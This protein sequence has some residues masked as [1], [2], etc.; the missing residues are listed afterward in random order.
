MSEPLVP[1]GSFADPIIGGQSV[2]VRDAIRSRNYVAGV[3]GWSINKDGTAELNGVV[4]RGSGI[5][6]TPGGERVEITNT[7]H[8]YIY[9]SANVLI[10]ALDSAGLLITDP[11][12]SSYAQTTLAAG[13]TVQALQPPAVVGHTYGPAL[14][15]GDSDVSGDAWAKVESPS[16]DGGDTGSILVYGENA[17]IGGPTEIRLNGERVKVGG[18]VLGIGR[19]PVARAYDTVDSAAVTAE[20]VVLT[21]TQFDYLD[22]RA[23]RATFGGLVS[24]SNA[25]A[26]VR[27]RLRKTNAGGTL[28]GTCGVLN[29]SPTAG[30]LCEGQGEFYFSNSTGASITAF[31]CL[32]LENLG[33]G[34]NTCQQRVSGGMNRWL[35]IEDCGD[36]VSH[37]WAF[38][39]T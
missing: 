17:S 8:I 38:P 9:D 2:L 25:N 5:F 26:R 31:I 29:G 37:D 36:T 11:A 33:G 23:Y 10:V 39:L 16:I 34:A 19:G 3:S 32:T 14:L 20:T 22:G 24:A 35:Y 6:G 12:T 4:I 7:G 1:F 18:N 21:A 30:D 13:F 28:L 27:A 15:Y